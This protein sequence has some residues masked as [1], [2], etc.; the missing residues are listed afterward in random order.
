MLFTKD[1]SAADKQGSVPMSTGVDPLAR[2]VSAMLAEIAGT[3][4]IDQLRGFFMAVGNR[5]ATIYPI[6]PART[7]ERLTQHSLL[8]WQYLNWGQVHYEL[9]DEG[10]DIFHRGLPITLEGDV[11]AIWSEVAP[12]I[13]QGTYD[14]WFRQLGSGERL[15]TTILRSDGADVELRHGV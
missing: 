11:G 13:L 9:D 6:G 14:G 3:A 1:F 12:F 7:M 10:I 5:I 2:L 8:I 15:E 4:T